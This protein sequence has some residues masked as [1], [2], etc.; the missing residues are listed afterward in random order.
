MHLRPHR[1]PPSHEAIASCAIQIIGFVAPQVVYAEYVRRHSF[2][3]IALQFF[4]RGLAGNTQ[5][6]AAN[7]KA[8]IDA[9]Q[10]GGESMTWSP[11]SYYVSS[12]DALLSP[13][14]A[15]A[16]LFGWTS[17]QR[18]MCSRHQ[19]SSGVPTQDG[20]PHGVERGRR[21]SP[22]HPRPWPVP[23]AGCHT[24]TSNDAGRTQSCH[25]RRK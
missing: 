13:R 9:V 8:A 17:M 7:P 23:A 6:D 10:F 14:C 24:E 22:C 1:K 3:Y 25:H 20:P 2:R 11:L 19:D 12:A 21:A 5:I 4:V 16:L 18:N 15:C